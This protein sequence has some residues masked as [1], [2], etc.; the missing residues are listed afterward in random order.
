MV[1]HKPTECLPNMI[2]KLPIVR[3]DDRFVVIDK[4]SGLLSVPGKGPDKADCVASRVREMFPSATGP[5]TV[6]RLDMDT[7]GLIL[8]ALDAEAHRTLSMQFEARTV[9]KAYIAL[10]AGIIEPDEGEIDLPI[11]AD[12]DNRPRQIHD[13]ILGKPSRTRY[14]VLERA[15]GITRVEFTPITGRSHQLR[16]HAAHELGLGTPILGDAL[17]G[18]PAP[19]ESAD[20][21]MLH[22]T[23]LEFDDPTDGS[24]VRTRSEPA[25]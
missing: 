17:Y 6:H 19:P 18:G 15:G 23:S 24:R 11:R 9:S 25:F 12:I 3:R 8:L 1:D 4:P 5:L 22:A 13:P 16:V 20:R 2:Q 10:L 7:S 21:L 14:R